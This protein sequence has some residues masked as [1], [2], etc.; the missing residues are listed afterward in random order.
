MYKGYFVGQRV[1]INNSEI[2][3]VEPIPKGGSCPFDIWVY[4]PSRGYACCFAYSSI[5]PLPN[6]QL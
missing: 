6:G 2:G 5:T 3:T 1:L 4:S